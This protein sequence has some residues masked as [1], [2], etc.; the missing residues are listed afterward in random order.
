MWCIGVKG[1]GIVAA[2]IGT[3]VAVIVGMYLTG[4]TECLWALLIPALVSG[5]L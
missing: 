5:L 3:S 4:S 1:I 2:W